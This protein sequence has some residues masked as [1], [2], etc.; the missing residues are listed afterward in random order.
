MKKK[1]ISPDMLEMG[2]EGDSV[3]LETSLYLTD[4]EKASSDEQLIG[5]RRRGY[6]NSW[7]HIWD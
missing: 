4:D 3:L 2:F 6:Y 1:Y 5:G 7:D